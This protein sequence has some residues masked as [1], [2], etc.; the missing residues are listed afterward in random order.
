MKGL[1][2]SVCNHEVQIRDSGEIEHQCD[3]VVKYM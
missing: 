2:Y 1:G 3:L